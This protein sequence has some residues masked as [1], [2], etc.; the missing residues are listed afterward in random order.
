MT[1]R[2]DPSAFGGARSKYQRGF[3]LFFF[4]ALVGFLS[5]TEIL[6][7]DVDTAETPG[8]I[9][10]PILVSSPRAACAWELADQG[11]L[12]NP[13][14]LPLL[15]W[16]R[17]HNIAE[18]HPDHQLG[19]FSQKHNFYVDTRDYAISADHMIATYRAGGKLYQHFDRIDTETGAVETHRW[20]FPAFRG[21]N[22]M[23]GVRAKL[24]EVALVGKMFKTI[25][26]H[27]LPH[28]TMKRQ[29]V[30][31]TSKPAYEIRFNYEPDKVIIQCANSE[32]IAQDTTTKE[33]HRDQ[34]GRTLLTTATWFS[35]AVQATLSEMVRRG[36]GYTVGI[37]TTAHHPREIA[38]GGSGGKLVAGAIGIVVDGVYTGV[39][40]FMDRSHPAAKK[41]ELY[42]DGAG[43]VA[44]F[45]ELDY[46]ESLGVKWVDSVTVNQAA[47]DFGGRFV[48]RQVFSGM[49]AEA[50][51][52]PIPFRLPPGGK[53]ELRY[54]RW[55]KANLEKETQEN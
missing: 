41:N 4:I 30:P 11:K 15:E 14:E 33:K 31:D 39:S 26:P 29:M 8:V 10:T 6:G 48:T 53:W 36:N 52:N 34:E 23:A 45:A 27:R 22:E 49:M 42:Y 35:P 25:Y 44:F 38:E 18:M 37:Y 13:L 9:Q 5:G 19:Y 2:I 40:L 20:E 47:R 43:R 28:P 16:R 1:L 17:L 21:I 24:Q 7:D 51:A 3:S 32:R 46:L 55:S 50:Q 12:N 54:D